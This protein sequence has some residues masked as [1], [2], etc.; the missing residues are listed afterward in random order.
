MLSLDGDHSY[1]EIADKIGKARSTIQL[2][3]KDYKEGK[4][5]QLLKRVPGNGKKPR[6]KA[7]HQKALLEKL[8]VG[9]FRTAWQ[10][11]EWISKEFGVNFSLIGT[12]YWLKKLGGKLK[13]PLQ[14][15]IKKNG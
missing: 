15:H 1:Q 6:L 12:Y 13:V 11:R 2:W 7:E 3:I 9:K 4:L 10:A 14:S 5:E 8:R